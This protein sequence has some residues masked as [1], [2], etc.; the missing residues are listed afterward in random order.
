MGG[1]DEIFNDKTPF[2]WDWATNHILQPSTDKVLLARDRVRDG[3]PAG[4]ENKCLV[5]GLFDEKKTKVLLQYSPCKNE[6]DL[7][8]NFN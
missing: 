6:N 2:P 8:G 5:V 4:F 1:S 3:K 7:R